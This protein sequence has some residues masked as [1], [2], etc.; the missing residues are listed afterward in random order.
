[1]YLFII[2]KNN[3]YNKMKIFLFLIIL[4]FFSREETIQRVVNS[5]GNKDHKTTGKMPESPEDCKDDDEPACKLVKITKKNNR[6]KN[7]CAI[8]HG[9][10]NDDDVIKEVRALVDAEKIE[11]L[12]NS[13]IRNKY[14][15]SFVFFLFY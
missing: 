9:K 12:G 2:N 8:I 11:V 4:L 6:D 7:F 3:K 10:Y 5:C 1:M 15:L 14:I 13:F